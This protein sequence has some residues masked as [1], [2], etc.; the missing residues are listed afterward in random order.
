[1]ATSTHPPEQALHEEGPGRR[2]GRRRRQLLGLAA[3]FVVGWLIG[4]L[5]EYAIGSRLVTGSASNP[6]SVAFGLPAA[7][8]VACALF[9]LL[10]GTTREVQVVDAPVRDPRYEHLGRAATSER[11]QMQGSSVAPRGPDDT[12]QR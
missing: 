10:L 1:M 3:G 8:G 6:F 7:V 11:G 4:F 9:G 2:H 5:V 12:A